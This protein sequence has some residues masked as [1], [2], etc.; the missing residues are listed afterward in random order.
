MLIVIS[1]KN[2]F[3]STS[4]ERSELGRGEGEERRARKERLLFTMV[5]ARRN[6]NLDCEQQFGVLVI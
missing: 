4:P 3:I 6:R 1:I 2:M 5:G